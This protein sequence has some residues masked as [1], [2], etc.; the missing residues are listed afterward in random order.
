MERLETQKDLGQL[1]LDEGKVTQEQLEAAR[2]V[3]AANEKSIGRVLMDMGLITDEVK[4]KFLH[5]KFH[6]EVVDISG[7]KV[8]IKILT[9]I[10]HSYAEKHRCVPILVEKSQLVVA[11][12]DP[13]NIVVHDEIKSETGMDILPV[14]APLKD[15][16]TVLEQY[17]QLTQAQA[18][19]LRLRLREPL[20]WRILHPLIFLI[21]M[22]SP[23]V[24]F[25]FSIAHWDNFLA[26][27]VFQAMK[28]SPFDVVLYLVLGWSLWAIA[29]WEVDGLVF[30]NPE[31]AKKPSA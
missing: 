1:L 20:W 9:R 17:P 18:D 19:E 24:F 15:I 8:P 23:F 4:I 10:S 5:N 14:L 22:L 13:T 21:L 7:M 30:V 12:E 2:S 16:D 29:L 3:Q 11:M 6:C 31:E 27:W 25:Y 28:Q 26:H